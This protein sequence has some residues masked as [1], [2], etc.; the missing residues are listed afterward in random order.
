MEILIQQTGIGF[1]YLEASLTH[2]ENDQDG[3]V[4]CVYFIFL[5]KK[6]F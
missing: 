6:S 3:C 4:L 1:R 2:L 5:E